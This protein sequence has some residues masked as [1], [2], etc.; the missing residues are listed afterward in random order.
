MAD[1]IGQPSPGHTLQGQV[2]LGSDRFVEKMRQHV[3]DDQSLQDIP[4]AQRRA[5]AKALHFYTETYPDRAQAITPDLSVLV[6]GGIP[7]SN[8][9]I[10]ARPVYFLPTPRLRWL[11]VRM[12]PRKERSAI[13]R[14]LSSTMRD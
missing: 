11:S 10:V 6:L 13:W 12:T 1:G 7:S 2:F 4:K 5:P 9:P 8:F 3:K 14:T